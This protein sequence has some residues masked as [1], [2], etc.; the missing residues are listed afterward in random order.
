MA[1]IIDGQDDMIFLN[2]VAVWAPYI[3]VTICTSDLSQNVDTAAY[4][5]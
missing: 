5:S 4:N 3:V 1:C 2:L